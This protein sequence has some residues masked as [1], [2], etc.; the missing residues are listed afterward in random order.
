ML[1][2]CSQQPVTAREILTEELAKNILSVKVLANPSP[3]YFELRIT[4]EANN[5]IQLK[6][7][8]L[9]GK[10]VETKSLHA[11]QTLRMGMSYSPGIY[12]VQI[13]QGT[14]TQTVRL[15]KTN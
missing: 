3:N 12:L 2:S 11:N 6:V 14:Q 7:Y 1:G 10:I 9:Q 4:G 5:S 13:I 8:D 15:V